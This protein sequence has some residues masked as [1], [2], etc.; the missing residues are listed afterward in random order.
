MLGNSSSAL[1]EAPVVRLPAVNVGI[2]QSGRLRGT[3]VIDASADADAVAAAL[4]QALAPAF[5]AGIDDHGPFGDGRSAQR[6]VGILRGWVPPQP[7][8]K[9]PI[10][11]GGAT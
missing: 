8:Q 11:V 4:Q 1:I 9:P 10:A 2:R 6:I 7:P 5:R 3:N